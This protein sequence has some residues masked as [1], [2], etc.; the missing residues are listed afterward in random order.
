MTLIEFINNDSNSIFTVA[1]VLMLFISILEGITAILGFGISSFLE[2][3]LPDLDLELGSA[4]AS[5]GVLSK[6]LS[7][8][9]YGKVPVLIIFVCFLTAFG[10]VGYSMQYM[11]YALTSSLLSQ[12]IVVPIALIIT[13]PFV[14]LFTSLLEKIM[15]KDETSA[16]SQ[17][18]FIGKVAVITLGK[19]SYGLPAEGKIK[20]KY[21]QTH[22]F[23]IEPESQE[24]EFIQGEDVLLSKQKLN[25]FYA[26]KNEH[27]SLK[28]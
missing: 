27:S 20:D 17:E 19:A 24:I 6:I 2:T 18:S 3:I 9:N 8:L 12:I 21:G 5:E 28:N 7:W 14:R 15:P 10:L 22:Y 13:F 11:F 23:M 16:L 26:I 4:D 1:L 25:G